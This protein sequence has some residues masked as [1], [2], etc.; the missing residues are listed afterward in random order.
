[1]TV[2][3]YHYSSLKS[4]LNLF[5]NDRGIWAPINKVQEI[6]ARICL[7]NSVTKSTLIFSQQSTFFRLYYPSQDHD[8][9]DTLWIP[10]E[11]YFFGLSKFLGT[12]R[13]V[14]KILNF[15]YGKISINL[16]CRL[17]NVRKPWKQQEFQTVKTMSFLL[18]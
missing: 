13:F 2:F 5:K 3:T 11:E 10:N 18:I 4:S 16:F 17:Q 15:F 14:A 9:F 1:M 6:A 12:P 7:R 8:H